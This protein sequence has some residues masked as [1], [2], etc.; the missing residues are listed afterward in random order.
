MK[1]Y[2]EPVVTYLLCIWWIGIELH[3]TQNPKKF[4]FDPTKHIFYCISNIP[5]WWFTKNKINSP[6]PTLH[7]QLPRQKPMYLNL[8]SACCS[9]SKRQYKST[10]CPTDIDIL[11]AVAMGPRITELPVAHEDFCVICKVC[12]SNSIVG[13]KLSYVK[14]RGVIKFSI[15]DSG[16]FFKVEPLF[17]AKMILNLKFIYSFLSWDFFHFFMH[18]IFFSR[19]W[20]N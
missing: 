19:K 15:S 5:R 3:I 4:V 8:V 17:E 9:S 1:P 14:C 20:I 13:K 2:F 7:L 16:Q 11:I 12:E 10:A 18:L 6:T